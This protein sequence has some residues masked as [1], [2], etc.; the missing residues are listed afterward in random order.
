[1]W[2]G[3]KQRKRAYILD[4]TRRNG[5]NTF[6]G[7]E[8][9]V[10]NDHGVVIQFVFVGTALLVRVAFVVVTKIT[11]VCILILPL[12]AAVFLIVEVGFLRPGPNGRFSGGTV[13]DSRKLRRKVPPRAYVLREP[14]HSASVRGSRIIV[15]RQEL[16]TRL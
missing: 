14:S 4:V 2:R 15:V 5:V 16:S 1:M 13:K 8:I 10:G 6:V 12:L 11:G 3:K 9:V 7:A